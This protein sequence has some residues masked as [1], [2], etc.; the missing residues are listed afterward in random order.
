MKSKT[1]PRCETI[2]DGGLELHVLFVI[3][4]TIIF[5]HFWDSA[6]ACLVRKFS[7]GWMYA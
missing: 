6:K 1:T 7:R 5:S 2:S 4:L 3:I